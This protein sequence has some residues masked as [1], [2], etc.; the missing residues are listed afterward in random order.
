MARGVD[1]NLDLRA[2]SHC[3]VVDWVKTNS[4]SLLQQLAFS[5]SCHFDWYIFPANAMAHDTLPH[6]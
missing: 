4:R 1:I 5:E 2:I 3:I 6:D